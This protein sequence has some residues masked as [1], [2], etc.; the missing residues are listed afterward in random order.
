LSSH[1]ATTNIDK[2]AIAT[3]VEALAASGSVWMVV[4]ASVTLGEI[5]SVEL[6]DCRS[7]MR[8][9]GY[10]GSWC[11]DKKIAVVELPLLLVGTG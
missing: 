8:N 4:L 11:G 6:L 5:P 3:T 1:E 7:D 9:L 10:R 2:L